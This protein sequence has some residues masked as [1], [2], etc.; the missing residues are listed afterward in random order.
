MFLI[1]KCCSLYPG[2]LFSF[3]VLAFAVLRAGPN[4]MLTLC[5][6]VWRHA[7]RTTNGTQQGCRNYLIIIEISPKIN[8]QGF[9]LEKKNNNV[10]HNM[11]K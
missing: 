8:K 1:L 3:L 7:K 9:F 6:S 4:S 10:F 2:K 5:M 11:I